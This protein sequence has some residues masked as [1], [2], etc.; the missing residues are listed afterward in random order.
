MKKQYISNK[1]QEV[2][3]DILMRLVFIRDINE[4]T[5]VFEYV[6]DKYELRDDPFTQLPC[7]R[8]EYVE[9]SYYYDKQKALEIYGYNDWF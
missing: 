4:L 3:V 8:K 7:T 9:S 5:E 2:A 1:M 6:Y